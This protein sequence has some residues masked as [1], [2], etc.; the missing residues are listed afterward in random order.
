MSQV[1]T[2]AFEQYWQSSLAAE[3]PVVLDEFILADIPNLDITAPIDPDTVLPPESQIVHRQ[4]VD[5]R[6]RINN[7]AVAYTIVMDTTVGDFSFN[8]MYLR[9]KQNGVIGMIVYKGR[10]TKLKTDQT[11]GQTGNSLVKSMLMGYD[12]AAEATITNVDAGTWQIDYAARLRG[13]DEDL[14]QLASQ[15]YGHHTFIGDGFKV[16]QQ[17]GGHQVTPGVAIVGGLRVELKAPEVIYPGSKPIGVWVDVHRAGSLLSEHQNHFTIIT[18]VADLTDHMDGSGYQHYVAKL[19]TVQ[20]DNT[21]VDSRG[22]GGS[23]GT[24]GIPDTFVLWKRSMAEA[25]YNVT[26]KFKPGSMVNSETDVLLD[27]KNGVAYSRGG[28][29][30]YTVSE[31]ET[32]EAEG[33]I[34]KY[35]ELLRNQLSRNDGLNMVGGFTYSSLRGYSGDG[36]GRVS[37][38]GRSNIF[39]G[40]QGTFF[41]LSGDTTTPDD[42]CTVIVDAAGR[43]WRRDNT[44]LGINVAWS[45]AIGFGGNDSEAIRKAVVAARFKGTVYIPRG[46]NCGIEDT[47]DVADLRLKLRGDGPEVSKITAMPSLTSVMLSQLNTGA[48][49]GDT[50][51]E[52]DGIGFYGNY[53]SALIGISQRHTARS[54]IKNVLVQGCGTGIRQIDNFV[55]LMEQVEIKDCKTNLHLVGSNHNSEYVRVGIVG[56]GDSFAGM[57]TGLLIEYSG[58]DGLQSSIAFRGCD[59]EFGSGDGAVIGVT[60]TVTFDNCYMEKVG[61]R[62]FVINDGDVVVKGGEYIIKDGSGYLVD[63]VG[64]NGRIYFKDKAGITSDGVSRLYQSLIKEDGTGLGKVYFE[65]SSV[66]Q[67]H[68]TSNSGFLPDNLGRIGRESPFLKPQ[69]RYFGANAYSGSITQSNTGDSKKVTCTAPGYIGIYQQMQRQ[70]M[71]NESSA[72]VIKYSSTVSL[73]VTVDSAAGQTPPINILGTLPNTNGEV[74]VRVIPNARITE[75]SQQW[76]E[77]WKG[78]NWGNG[79][80]ITLYEVW[81]CSGDSIRNGVLSLG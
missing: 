5:Q 15:L 27:E 55:H 68:L 50:F 38:L 8:A 36:I 22:Q 26:G 23:S 7:N 69:G 14:R 31:G 42:D 41:L 30:P 34:D 74:K 73:N 76:L 17:A 1:I 53:S 28:P 2:N 44:S 54:T 10:E 78:S 47:I 35:N 12:Q 60:G 65:S 46:Y 45:G 48:D 61:G 77:L 66:F 51:E 70:P 67:R 58:N 33:W 71:L 59:I 4:S 79:E 75:A 3:Q 57:G 56:F 37:V 21:V 24:G 6:G 19:G 80:T 63:P 81:W 64:G 29:Y 52:I 32:P 72:L 11:T 39:D 25:G 9:N 13:Q 49:G 18:S 16:V 62:M 43:R 40:G 20:A